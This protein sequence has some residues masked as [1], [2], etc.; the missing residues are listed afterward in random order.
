MTTPVST[1]VRQ[2]ADRE[3]IRECLYR[4]ARG[5]D[6]LDAGM[7]RSAYWPDCVDNHT[8]FTGNAEEF[9]AWAFPIMG[10]MDQTMHLIAN[11]LMTIRGESADV[12]SYFYGIHR[13]TLPD[14]GKSDVI[15]AGRYI[16]GFEKRGEEWRIARRHVI[17]DWFRQY[18]DSADWSR[19]MLGIMIAPGGRFPDDE[20]YTRARIE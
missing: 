4:Y 5:V 20:S 2:L 19:G 12:E 11:V 10:T 18:P 6:R 7:V 13:I 1:I 16:D 14:G 9:I 3:A 8:G 15:G 17:T